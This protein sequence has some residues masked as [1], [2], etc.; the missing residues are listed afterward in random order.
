M[1]LLEQSQIQQQSL[2]SLYERVLQ[3]F[4]SETEQQYHKHHKVLTTM[5]QVVLTY[6]YQTGEQEYLASLHTE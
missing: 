2:L 5:H 1:D 3:G 6:Q 4:W